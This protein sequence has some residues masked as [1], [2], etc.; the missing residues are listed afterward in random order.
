MIDQKIPMKAQNKL[1]KNIAQRNPVHHKGQMD[2]ASTPPPLPHL[3]NEMS[4]N[5]L[6]PAIKKLEKMN[7]VTNNSV[8]NHAPSVRTLLGGGATTN[9]KQSPKQKPSFTRTP[10][11][12][13]KEASINK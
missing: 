9:G 10:F 2:D 4:T 11:D 5:S 13:Q 8:I 3:I 12:A 1:H 6:L 7:T